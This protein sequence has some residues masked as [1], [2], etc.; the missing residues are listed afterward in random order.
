M[1]SNWGGGSGGGW[2]F[3]PEAVRYRGQAW[4]NLLAHGGSLPH[5]HSDYSH[6]GTQQSMIGSRS[7][8]DGL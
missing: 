1:K 2:G 6:A 8:K 3:L 5:V 4:V 7:F